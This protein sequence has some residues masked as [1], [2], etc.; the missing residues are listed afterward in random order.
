MGNEDV[1]L[2]ESHLCSHS[3]A[4]SLEEF[5]LVESE[6]VVDENKMDY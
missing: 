2:L 6:T 3:C 4:H 5:S 1:S